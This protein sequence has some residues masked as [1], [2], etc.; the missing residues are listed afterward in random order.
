MFRNRSISSAITATVVALAYSLLLFAG[1]IHSVRHWN[2]LQTEGKNSIHSHSSSNQHQDKIPGDH[3][4][5]DDEDG[6]NCSLC[7]HGKFYS[8]LSEIP[9]KTELTITAE[10][11]PAFVF[12]SPENNRSLLPRLRA[13]P[14]A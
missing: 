2:G 13:P 10:E 1:S 14:T 5:P 3:Q 7:L 6:N 11:F 8:S 4:N 12:S 9:Y